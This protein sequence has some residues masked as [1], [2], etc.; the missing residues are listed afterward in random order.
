[1]SA[2]ETLMSWEPV[3][4]TAWVFLVCW[5]VQRAQDS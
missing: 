1:M 2:L 4:L 3:V 5:L